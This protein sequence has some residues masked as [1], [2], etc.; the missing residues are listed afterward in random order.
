MRCLKAFLFVA[1][2]A[3]EE[4]D[5]IGEEGGEEGE[6]EEEPLCASIMLMYDFSHL[7]YLTTRL[8]INVSSSYS[9]R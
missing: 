2:E 8:V 9:P 5:E 1:K 4:E 7:E 3:G 6:E